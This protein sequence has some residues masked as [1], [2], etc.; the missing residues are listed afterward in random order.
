MGMEDLLKAILGGAAAPQEQQAQ[1]A[2][3]DP[4][5]DLL[6][7]ILG[8]IAAP[9][10]QSEQA[11][12]G[13]GLPDLLGGILGGGAQGG[14]DIGDILGG[15][16]GGGAQD[17]TPQGG[18]G[19]IL[20]GILGGGGANLGGHSFLG[21]IVEGLAKKL[22]LSPAIAQAV[23]AFAVSKLLP[24][25]LGRVAAPAPTPVPVQPRRARQA[26]PQGLDLDDLLERMGS[27]SR[28]RLNRKYLQSTGLASELA[29]QTELDTDTAVK[30][31][32]EVLL[33]LGNQLGGTQSPQPSKERGLD[34]MLDS[35]KVK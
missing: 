25:L 18:L 2:G 9:E 33:A 29:Q 31:L 34:D 5:A 3:G 24:M 16:L 12:I 14:V 8:G 15:I 1:Q 32:Q 17:A 23:V 20:G 4:L 13:G 10:E 6:G 26:Q 7:G 35:W 22:G 27:G 19:G 28:R 11:G 21:P 30:S